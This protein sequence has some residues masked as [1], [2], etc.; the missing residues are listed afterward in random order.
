M[1]VL[2]LRSWAI[3]LSALSILLFSA[4]APF[5]KQPQVLGDASAV[6]KE[7]FS[8]NS[9]TTLG[10]VQSAALKGDPD[11][12]YALGYAY[13][14]GRGVAADRE[15]ALEWIHKA[16]AQGQPQA[17]AALQLLDS[18][19]SPAAGST[20]VTPNQPAHAL[21]NQRASASQ[22]DIHPQIHK[23]H[24]QATADH[25]PVL[26]IA[27]DVSS[28]ALSP[29]TPKVHAKSAR[30]TPVKFAARRPQARKNAEIFP[31][32]TSTAKHNY[33]TL[34]LFGART[35][36]E[37]Q[38]FIRSQGL[39]GKAQYSRTQFNNKNWYP[40][41]Y[42]QYPTAVAAHRALKTLPAN[43]QALHPWVKPVVVASAEMKQIHAKSAH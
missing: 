15:H 22:Q 3:A 30:V 7:D 26:A 24:T 14:Y 43:I 35:A 4:C 5:A 32:A 6:A 17:L 40:V 18:Q 12:E 37:S 2:R 28:A 38:N 33:F 25:G 9:Q 21:D 13:Y 8:L 10:A 16:A 23:I 31:V 1:T 41:T 39:T 42:G 36:A 29:S 19:S 11:A 20:Q 27:P 34:Q